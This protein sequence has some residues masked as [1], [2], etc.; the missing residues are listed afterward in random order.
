MNKVQP[1][2][3]KTIERREYDSAWK[4]IIEEHFE[5]FLEFFFEDIHRD[6][7]FSKGYEFLSQELRKII[8]SNKVGKKIADV[9]VKVYLKDGSEK[10]ICIFIHIEIQGK[11]DPELMLRIYI[12]NYRI[13]DKYK[14]KNIEVI[15][16]AVLTD[17]DE[18]YRP[19]EYS[20]K[21]CG[22]ELRL[23]IPIV[24]IIDYQIKKELIEKLESSTSPMAMVVK[25]QLRSFEAKRNNSNEKFNIKKNLIRQCLERGYTRKQ[26]E[27]L[28]K[29]ID[30]I[31]TLPE[32]LENQLSDEISKIEEEH[33]MAYV[34]SWERIAEKRGRLE[35]KKEG[36]IEGKIEGERKGKK[37]GKKE[38]IIETAR[39]MLND[40]VPIKSIARYTG[41]DE[42]TIR[43]LRPLNIPENSHS[44][45]V[46]QV[47]H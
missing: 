2:S 32:G 41:L 29:F 42:K 44:S 26:I 31:I 47:A 21:R 19:D 43:R 18:K 27:S 37:E 36:K 34:T 7:D 22:F 20:V 1:T 4:D 15:S 33:K 46:S 24:K 14:D 5:S 40:N 39:R 16:L 6:I 3:K 35:G 23:K 45:S 38:G 30:W 13:F 9:L 12:Y 25:A 8:R 28:I 11:K 17:E 10:Y